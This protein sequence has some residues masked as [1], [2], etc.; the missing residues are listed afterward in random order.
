MPVGITIYIISFIILVG[1][2][3]FMYITDKKT[4]EER[5]KED[6]EDEKK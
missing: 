3:I 1:I 5:R 2:C 6:E 4:I